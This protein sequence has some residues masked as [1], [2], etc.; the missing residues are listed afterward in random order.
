MPNHLKWRDHFE[1]LTYAKN[2]NG[3]SRFLK[4]GSLYNFSQMQCNECSFVCEKNKTWRISNSTLFGH[5]TI[6]T[7]VSSDMD[8]AAVSKRGNFA[9]FNVTNNLG[10]PV[11]DLEIGPAC[12]LI[13]TTCHECF[14]FIFSIITII[15]GGYK[16]WMI[17]VFFNFYFR[18]QQCCQKLHFLVL[19]V[20]V[21]SHVKNKVKENRHKSHKPCTCSVKVS[22]IVGLSLRFPDALIL[23]LTHF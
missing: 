18:K 15:A 10:V 1:A 17:M 4:I 13:T 19:T 16:N 20:C 9:A 7:Q 23:H 8:A 21:I 6:C 14:R 3:D 22:Q 2:I 12:R 5:W 11:L